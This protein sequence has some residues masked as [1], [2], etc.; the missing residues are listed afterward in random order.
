M[1]RVQQQLQG[2]QALLAI[3]DCSNLE[4]PNQVR[5]LLKNDGAKEVGLWLD[6]GL[7]HRASGH[8]KDVPP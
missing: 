4:A 1:E 5:H 3:Y 8:T 7:G 6:T 2:R